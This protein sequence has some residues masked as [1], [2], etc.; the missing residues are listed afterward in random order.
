VTGPIDE[1]GSRANV[2]EK[3]GRMFQLLDTSKS[4]GRGTRRGGEGRRQQ[5][6]KKGGFG[7]KTKNA[8]K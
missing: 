5:W 4:K 6:E 8:K 7:V 1:K 3:R 2:P